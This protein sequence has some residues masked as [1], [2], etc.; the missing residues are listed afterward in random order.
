MVD[1]E[2]Q[3]REFAAEVTD[4]LN[5]TVTDGIRLKSVIANRRAT[6]V[7]VGYGI[8]SKDL[9]AKPVPL[10]IRRTPP[11]CHLLVAYILGLDPEQAHL[12]VAKS[13]Y[14]LYLDS[15]RQ[16]MLVHWDYTRDPEND[17]PVAHVQVNGDCEHF[18]TL[19]EKA[20]NAGRIS[21]MRPLRDF[22][23]PVGGR[24][25]RPALEDVV[26]FLV[27]EGLAEMRNDWETVVKE[28]RDRWEEHQ[29]R[30]AVRRFPEI[31]LQQLRED[32]QIQV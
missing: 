30:A 28:H 22:H 12:A 18:D 1:L 9:T 16:K 3:A 7:H 26:E 19:T 20:R 25:F 23:F 6:T 21:P 32:R 27:V 4:L 31:A 2:G 5:R 8:S 10:G 14:G 17:Y 24:R 13:Q 11:A 29:L 15:D